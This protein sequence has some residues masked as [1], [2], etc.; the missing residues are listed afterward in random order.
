MFKQYFLLPCISLVI[1]MSDFL[2]P[3]CKSKIQTKPWGRTKIEIKCECYEVDY[4]IT[5]NIND[6]IKK[7]QKEVLICPLMDFL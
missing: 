5:E 1:I 2:C 4:V 7:Y 6:L 3:K